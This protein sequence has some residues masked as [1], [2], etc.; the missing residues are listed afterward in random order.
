[1]NS[2]GQADIPEGFSRAEFTPGFLDYGGPYYLKPHDGRHIVGL[3]VLDQHMNY[4]DAAHGGVLS[5]LA[6]VGLS[7]QVYAS[8]DPPIPVTT[9]NLSVNFLSPAKLGDWL[10]ADMH[11]DRLGRRVA[12]C[13][14][15]IRRGEDILATASGSFAVLR[16]G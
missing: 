1:M 12:Y 13:S 7:W 8:E 5:T 6:D 3:Q 2:A 9:I 11:V 4:R 10:E 15:H 16:G 14:G